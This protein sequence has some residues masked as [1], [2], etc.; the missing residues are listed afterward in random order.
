MRMYC[1]G[2]S[3]VSRRNRRSSRRRG[4]PPPPPAPRRRPA[5]LPMDR[6][7]GT[8][9][10]RR[11]HAAARLRRHVR[12]QPCLGGPPRGRRS[13]R[14]A[15]RGDQRGQRR[16]QLGE[17]HLAVRGA[18]QRRAEQRGEPARAEAHADRRDTRRRL[19]DPRPRQRA[20]EER[21]RLAHEPP[22]DDAGV[23]IAAVDDQLGAAVGNHPIGRPR[24]ARRAIG[25]A[26]DALDRRGERSR[27][28]DVRRN[29]G[30]RSGRRVDYPVAAVPASSSRFQISTASHST[31][32]RTGRGSVSGNVAGHGGTTSHA[33]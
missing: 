4:N 8:G 17:R 20:G 5:P 25:H 27:A 1:F 22:V 24:D 15:D 28:P 16:G 18:G 29:G 31:N 13:A 3:A 21:R 26:P 7:H 14:A 32:R 11:R 9:A 10:R 2:V 33:A 19:H 12:Q 6:A 23:A 30:P